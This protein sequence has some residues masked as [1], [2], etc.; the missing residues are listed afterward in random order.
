MLREDVDATLELLSTPAAGA[1]VVWV[2]RQPST[3]LAANT[4]VALVVL[5]EV[6]EFV[7][8]RVFPNLGPCPLGQRADLEELFATREPVPL[9]FLEVFAGHRL[10]APQSREPD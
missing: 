1:R 10:L 3:R 7:G 2:I 8:A 4:Q 9:N 6:A 5:G